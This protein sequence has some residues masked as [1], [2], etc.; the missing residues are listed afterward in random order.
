M[1]LNAKK[2]IA[3]ALC[4]AVLA[5]GIQVFGVH[6]SFAANFWHAVSWNPTE[7]ELPVQNL[8]NNAHGNSVNPN[9][10]LT[11]ASSDPLPEY[12][13]AEMVLTLLPSLESAAAKMQAQGKDGRIW[14][15]YFQRHLGF[16][17][18]QVAIM[19][20]V[21][22]EFGVAVQATH[23]RARAIIAQRRA[24]RA[25]GQPATPPPAE[26]LALQQQRQALALQYGNRLRILLGNEPYQQVK[27]ILERNEPELRTL[28][29][30]TRQQI[31]Q[32]WNNRSANGNQNASPMP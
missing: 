26:L 1:T 28:T 5:T 11:P 4:V 31:R 18:Q 20:Q 27:R 22:N 14:S 13:S 3:V 10:V 8:S 21:A 32:Q 23:N 29:P 15:N 6:T 17:Q 24:A 16:T 30:E 9:P 19:R 2:I 12:A 7:Q 25:S